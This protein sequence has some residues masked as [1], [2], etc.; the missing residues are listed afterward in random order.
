MNLDFRSAQAVQGARDYAL[1]CRSAAEQVS[2]EPVEEP[3]E[4]PVEAS[5][6]ASA[7]RQGASDRAA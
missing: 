5:V 3:V 4:R 7:P 2:Q 6:T 1:A